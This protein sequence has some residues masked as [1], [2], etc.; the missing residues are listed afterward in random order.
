MPRTPGLTRQM[1]RAH[2]DHVFRDVLAVRPLRRHEW[3]L[4]EQDLARRLEN[5]GW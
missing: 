1:V 3:R 5:A 2:A 4:A